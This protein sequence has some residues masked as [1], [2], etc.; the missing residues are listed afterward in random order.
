MQITINLSVLKQ[1]YVFNGKNLRKPHFSASKY[2]SSPWKNIEQDFAFSLADFN[3]SDGNE[4]SQNGRFINFQGNFVNLLTV[5]R[6]NCILAI[7]KRFLAFVPKIN[8]NVDL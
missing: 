4:F 8:K 7:N 5:P 3:Y 1:F 6:Q 2:T